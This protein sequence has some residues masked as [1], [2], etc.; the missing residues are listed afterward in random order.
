MKPIHFLA[1]AAALVVLASL[2][3]WANQG[4]TF[5]VGLA[6]VEAV[7]AL[8]WNLLFG[9]TGMA[10]FGHAA[11]FAIGGY[12]CGAGLR[13]ATGVPFLA[14]LGGAGA[15][16]ALT[17][18]LVGLVALRRS[19]GIHFAILTLALSEVLRVLIAY[20]TALGR[21]DGLSA[22]PRPAVNL[23]VA[24]LD[25]TSGQSYYWF[26]LVA[27]AL[28]AWV[29][30]LVAKGPLGRVLQTIRQDPERAAF[31]GVD[32]WRY[33]LGAFTLSGA[34]AAVSGALYA[35]WAQIITPDSA[36]WI[37]S[38]QPMLASLLG[39]AQSFWGP[40]IGTILF[41][42]INYATRTLIGL[43]EIVI[44]V[45]LLVIVLS[46]PSGV[47]GLLRRFESRRNRPAAAA[48]GGARVRAATVPTPAGEA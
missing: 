45:V 40:V 48:G 16:G 34:V 42:A 28:L 9:F 12:L 25:L 33:R 29:L 32:V 5:I 26:L 43:S 17:A 21:E 38:T 44:G 47:M 8:S 27:S 4:V 10:S 7:F 37:H 41:T 23:G 2:P 36:H 30:W 3:V 13:Y 39:G 22:I 46:A 18:F 19:S 14:L 35:P 20:S 11:F 15:L 31:M 6:L 1:I 24:R